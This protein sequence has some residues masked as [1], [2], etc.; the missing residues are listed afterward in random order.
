LLSSPR[1]IEF[2]AA[3]NNLIYIAFTSHLMLAIARRTL[4][5]NNHAVF[6]LIENMVEKLCPERPLLLVLIK[7]TMAK[8]FLRSN[9][10]LWK[11]VP[12]VADSI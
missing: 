7:N 8:A 6:L 9:L 10:S 3:Y 5:T 11:I 12:A 2:L 4:C 1:L